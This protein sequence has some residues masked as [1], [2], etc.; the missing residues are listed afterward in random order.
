MPPGCPQQRLLLQQR[1][2]KPS[3]VLRALGRRAADT[4]VSLR[5]GLGRGVT[6]A[7]IDQDLAAVQEAL[8]LAVY[9]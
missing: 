4:T 5:P 3:H 1:Q 7:D 2:G 9:G 6:A 8:P